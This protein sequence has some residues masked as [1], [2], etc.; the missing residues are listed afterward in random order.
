MTRS[1]P[2][3]FLPPRTKPLLKDPELRAEVSSLVLVS[4]GG[5]R[6]RRS[7]CFKKKKEF[8]VVGE[9]KVKGGQIWFLAIIDLIADQ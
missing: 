7:R 9:T 8:F 3:T 1:S 6:N 4:A 5:C 2:I